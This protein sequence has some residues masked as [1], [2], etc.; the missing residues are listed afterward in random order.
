M[1]EISNNQ[2]NVNFSTEGLTDEQMRDKVQSIQ[3]RMKTVV[4]K[5]HAL[6]DN[7]DVFY[8]W[9]DVHDKKTF[10]GEKE[11]QVCRFCGVKKGEIA[12]GE[13]K[14]CTF[15]KEAHALSNLIGNNHLFSYYEC[16][17]CNGELFTKMESHFA[18]FMN[19]Y[20]CVL[21]VKGKRGY[22]SYKNKPDDFSRID[23]GN[24]FKIQQKEDEDPLVEIHED[25]NKFIIKGKRTYIPQMVYKCLL[26]MA[27]TVMPESDIVHFNYALAFLQ[28][29][30]LYDKNMIVILSMYREAFPH[31][32]CTIYKKKKLSSA[33]V[34]SY[35]FCLYYQN[36]AF[37][38]YLPFC[39]TDKCLDGKTITIP[40]VPTPFDIENG[41]FCQCELDLS[42]EEKKEKERCEITLTYE[43]A[44]VTESANPMVSIIVPV[45]KVPEQYLRQCIESCMNQTM[46]EIE[47]ILVDDGSPD[48]CGKICDEYAE[49]DE[50]VKVIHKE[51]GGLAAARN[52][53]QDAARGE[54]M[55]FLDGD[56]YLELDCCENAYSRL[57]DKDVELVMFDQYVNYPNSQIVQ[58]SFNNGKGERLFI[59]D[60]CR[61]LQSRVLDFNGR[62]AMAFMKLIRIDYLRKHNIRHVD[63]LRQ[64]AEGFVFNIQ[65]FEHIERAY[66]LNKPL[67]HYIYNGQSI[68][69]TASVKNNLLIV[70]CFEWIDEYVKKSRNPIELHPGVLNRMLYVICTTA[71]TGYF[72]PYNKQ[73]HREKVAG[74]EDFMKE[75]LVQEAL[76]HAPRKGINLQRRIILSL[77]S[78]R[79]YK[80]ISL[81][82]W[83]R[84]KQLENK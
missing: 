39:D 73:T 78:F 15:K 79:M 36:V 41:P 23:S 9:N 4:D 55:M 31:I 6:Y 71:I 33:D 70:R 12:A 57:K 56:D 38:M 2:I 43:R 20:H 8:S 74:F 28:G 66:Y 30:V 27:L 75:R 47:I 24:N 49:R 54:T 29:K 25:T 76:S 16:D 67:L 11:N 50:R 61:W 3:H 51:N 77:I 10:L 40:F 45:Y 65:L 80:A 63:E 62:I 72:N 58:H 83:L 52:T 26:K 7:Y 5:A 42:S 14:P 59:G 35:L 34:P 60:D 69:H 37:Q 64:G 48:D 21:K 84:R 46:R 22:P 1:I 81:L 82:G 32:S 17:K 19:L 68:S 18:N 13:S 44:E 53:G